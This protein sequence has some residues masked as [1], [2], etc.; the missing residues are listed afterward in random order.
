MNAD[1]KRR[2]WEAHCHRMAETTYAIAHW[3]EDQEMMEAYIKLA[4]QWV[5]MADQDTPAP[6]SS[7]S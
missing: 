5:R 6:S 4:A 7:H 2:R 1:A 3:C